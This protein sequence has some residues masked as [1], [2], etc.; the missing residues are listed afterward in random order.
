VGDHGSEKHQ[1]SGENDESPLFELKFLRCLPMRTTVCAGVLHRITSFLAGKEV[2]PSTL[3]G[4]ATEPFASLTLKI[5]QCFRGRMDSAPSK[6]DRLDPISDCPT[7][8]QPLALID[9][10]RTEHFPKPSKKGQFSMAFALH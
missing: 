3:S 8:R 7:F 2:G 4:L 5:R 9:K 6:L 1:S 10:R